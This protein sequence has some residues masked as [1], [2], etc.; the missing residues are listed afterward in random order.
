MAGLKSLILLLYGALVQPQE[1]S[2]PTCSQYLTVD[3]LKATLAP[4]INDLMDERFGRV[5]ER[6]SL[7]ERF[8]TAT[9]VSSL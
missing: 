9:E 4:I 2:R 5:Q 6:D 3:E 1:T 7:L 8:I